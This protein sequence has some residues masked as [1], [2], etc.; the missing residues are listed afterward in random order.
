MAIIK[1]A[2]L[3]ISSGVNTPAFQASLSTGT[4]QTI[5]SAAYTKA[6]LSNEHFD[7]D[8][9]YDTSNGRFTVPTGKGGK[10]HIMA[11]SFIDDIDNLITSQIRIFKNG[12]ATTNPVLQ[13]NAHGSGGSQN[14]YINL[15]QTL[16]L[17]ESDYIEMF[18]YQGTSTDQNLR[19]TS[20]FSAYR[21]IG[22]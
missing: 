8:N 15:S 17:A 10:Y 3:G 5:P 18:V 20:S 7:T 1:V 12:S 22:A 11:I 19:S 6:I 2:D 4:S 9:A 13:V 14:W 16:T 21:I